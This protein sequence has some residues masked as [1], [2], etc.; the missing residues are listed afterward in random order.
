MKI[1]PPAF[2]VTP[3]ASAPAETSFRGRRVRLSADDWAQAALDQIAEAGIASVAVE[4]MARKLGVTKGSFYWHF[5][6][7]DALIGAALYRWEQLEMDAIWKHLEDIADPSKRLREMIHI[8]AHEYKSHKVFIE[9]VKAFDHPIVLPVIERMSARRLDYLTRSYEQSG[10]EPS[11]A[12]H[13]ANLIYSAYVGFIQL[14]ANL[15]H[16]RMDRDQYNAFV[17][18]I[19]ETMAP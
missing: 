3:P 9:L 14:N 11:E 7:R 1:T 5:P 18:H 6:S 2:V 8:I 10:L 16:M 4:S 17:E 15:K 19:V 12:R 13:R